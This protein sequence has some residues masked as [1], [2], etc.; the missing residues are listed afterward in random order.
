MY[1][2]KEENHRI[3]VSGKKNLKIHIPVQYICQKQISIDE[4]LLRILLLGKNP[5]AFVAVAES[6]KSCNCLGLLPISVRVGH[7]C[8]QSLWKLIVMKFTWYEHEDWQFSVF[9]FNQIKIAYK[10]NFKSTG[11]QFLS[12]SVHK[13]SP[14]Y[15]LR[16]DFHI[17]LHKWHIR[18]QCKAQSEQLNIRRVAPFKKWDSKSKM[19]LHNTSALLKHCRLFSLSYHL[20]VSL[21]TL[22]YLFS[23]ATMILFLWGLVTYVKDLF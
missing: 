8:N 23:P 22:F 11:N 2:E 20:H 7:D 15:H 6:I 14:N 1:P 13:N 12:F 4:F 19:L 18:V 10:D 21:D 16:S 9:S 17:G 5:L 3:V